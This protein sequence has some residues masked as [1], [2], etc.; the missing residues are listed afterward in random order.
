[1]KR[2]FVFEEGVK[3]LNRMIFYEIDIMIYIN[4]KFY[5]VKKFFFYVKVIVN[6]I[7]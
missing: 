5:I 1:M 6:L 2:V 7:D 4:G 3:W